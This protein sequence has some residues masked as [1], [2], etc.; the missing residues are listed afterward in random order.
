VSLHS[1][2]LGQLGLPVTQL[3]VSDIELQFLGALAAGRQVQGEQ[4]A[5]THCDRRGDLDRVELRVAFF[6]TSA[7]AR[8]SIHCHSTTSTTP[9]AAS[10]STA[11]T[12]AI[13]CGN[14]VRL[15]AALFTVVR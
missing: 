9:V 12:S 15:G 2:A 13:H 3:G 10:T 7:K 14:G 5:A 11:T 6:S 8:P 1:V 4:A